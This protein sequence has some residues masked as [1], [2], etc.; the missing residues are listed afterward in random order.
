MFHRVAV[1]LSAYFILSFALELPGPTMCW[2]FFLAEVAVELNMF[3]RRDHGSFA[4]NAQYA[5]FAL[6]LIGGT[7]TWCTQVLWHSMQRYSEQSAK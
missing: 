1:T 2:P 7:S 3:W 6:V 5:P 4:S